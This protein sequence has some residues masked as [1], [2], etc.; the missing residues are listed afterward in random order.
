MF[1]NTISLALAGTTEHSRSLLWSPWPALDKPILKGEGAAETHF[2]SQRK[3]E[4]RSALRALHSMFPMLTRMSAHSSYGGRGHV[5]LSRVDPR[6]SKWQCLSRSKWWDKESQVVAE[7]WL[8]VDRG[9]LAL[10]GLYLTSCVTLNK[11]GN[12]SDPQCTH[13]VITIALSLPASQGCCWTHRC[14]GSDMW[15]WRHGSY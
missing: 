1:S 4:D 7:L 15:K 9:A 14:E 11:P 13:L 8:Y 12:V 2:L 3:H 6:M 10:A 5:D